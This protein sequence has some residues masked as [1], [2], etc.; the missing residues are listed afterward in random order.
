MPRGSYA[1]GIASRN[2][3]IHA[4][5]GL[6]LDQGYEKTSTASIAVAAGMSPSTFFS[7]FDTKEELLLA[8]VKIMFDGQFSR[9]GELLGGSGDPV[10]LYAAETALQLHITE[11]S[12]PLREIYVDAYTLPETSEYIYRR[13]AG[14]VGRLFREFLP[15]ATEADHYEFELAAAGVTRSFMARPCDMYFTMERKLRRYI[16]CVLNIYDVPKERRE[17]AIEYVLGLDLRP[18][19]EKL[20]ADAVAAAASSC[21]AGK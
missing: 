11:L 5:M 3:M 17:R 8:L 6:F 14:E 2:R 20:V 15:E 7:A 16:D 4:A 12:A 10:M 13:M 21:G 9:A 18:Q 1:K 19:A